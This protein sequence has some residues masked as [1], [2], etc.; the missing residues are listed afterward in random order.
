MMSVCKI[1]ALFF[2]AFWVLACQFR[3][4]AFEKVHNETRAFA[5]SPGTEIQISNKYGNVHIINWVKDSVKFEIS[6]VVNSIKQEKVEKTLS[7]IDFE[8]T[9]TSRYIIAKTIFKNNQGSFLDEVNNLANTLFTSSNTVQIDYKVYMPKTCPVKIEN[10][11]GNIFMTDFDERVNINLSNGDLKA[12]EF[13]KDLDLKIDFGS[14]NIKKVGDCKIT[15]GYAE[16]EI[17]Q[18]GKMKLDC[19]SSAFDFEVIETLEINSRRDKIN[20]GKVK[21]IRGEL[22][23]SELSVDDFSATALLNANY[24]EIDMKSV[25]KTFGQI[26][27]TAKYTEISLNFDKESAFNLVIG[28]S[29]QTTL[30]N[31]LGASN[32]KKEVLDEKNGLYQSSG[33]I[34]TGKSLP[35]V[36]INILSGQ[37]S[38]TNF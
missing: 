16:V 36:K 32:L 23:F 18:A 22:S 1:K 21:S 19:K 12:N 38:L 5:I 13:L 37:V 26:N 28:Y 10:K 29:K 17:N 4:E 35:E 30:S 33:T 34:G 9:P 14:V 2:I 27:I 15:A 20:I 3:A 24:G 11:F 8:F 7:A 31:T 25:E 6:V